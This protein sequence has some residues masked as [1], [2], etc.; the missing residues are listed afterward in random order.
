MIYTVTLNPALD[1][2]VPAG[3]IV[4]G[5]VNRCGQGVF[6]AG[7][8][9]INVSRALTSLGVGNRALAIAAGF[10]GREAAARLEAAG[11]PADFL[12]LAS[13]CTRVNYKAAH[14]D[15]SVTEL[16]GE[17]PPVP[18]SAVSRLGG[19]LSAL[20]PGDGLVLAGSVPAS[21]PA[22]V[23]ARLLAFAKEGVRTVV[24]TTGEALLAALAARPFLI[25]PNLEELG[26]V[27]GAP[28]SGIG[29]AAACAQRLCAMGAQNVVVS[30]GERGALLVDARG[31]RFFCR[32]AKGRA[33]SAVGAGDSL[34]AGFLYG[35]GQGGVEE[36]LRWGV[37]A[38]CA[39]AFSGDIC[40]GAQARALYCQVGPA[41]PL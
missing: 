30:M 31:R 23:Y 9:G 4:P 27:S 28:V 2:C 33:V 19:K 38:G 15:G 20:G 5:G 39:T 25:K 8:K 37:A 7:G 35:L 14:P 24:D 26:G 41:R 22:D 6:R 10:T 1:L 34:V 17:G 36:A 21:L 12:F 11:C 13:G 29:E 18:L 3:A 16:N 32:A 40:A